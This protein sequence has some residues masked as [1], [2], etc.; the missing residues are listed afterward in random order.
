MYLLLG[1]VAF[2]LIAAALGF[3]AQTSARL[4]K[5]LLEAVAFLAGKAGQSCKIII[6]TQLYEAR[7][8]SSTDHELTILSNYQADYIPAM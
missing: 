6:P 4:A 5:V 1:F 7:R 3:I 8:T 2:G